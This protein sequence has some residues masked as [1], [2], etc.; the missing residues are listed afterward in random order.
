MRTR[1]ES[2]ASA[3]IQKSVSY[4]SA[5]RIPFSAWIPSRSPSRGS[6]SVRRHGRGNHRYPHSEFKIW[7]WRL[8]LILSK[9]STGNAMIL[10]FQINDIYRIPSDPPL[11]AI[12]RPLPP[13]VAAP[14]I[15][16]VDLWS[17]ISRP[18]LHRSPQREIRQSLDVRANYGDCLSIVLLC[19]PYSW[20][21]Y[22]YGTLWIP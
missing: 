13:V 10:N 19:L 22:P 6:S 21:P 14:T 9:A 20:I 15:V 8:I 16:Q 4:R 11:P 1:I 7:I 5:Y 12:D 3:G 18:H 17:L 2:P